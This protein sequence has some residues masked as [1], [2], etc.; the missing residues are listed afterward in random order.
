MWRFH[1]TKQKKN[2]N[3]FFARHTQVYVVTTFTFNM[4]AFA[5]DILR[6][7]TAF[8]DKFK[9]YVWNNWV[10]GLLRMDDDDT[11]RQTL[12]YE[13]MANACKQCMYESHE[14]DIFREQLLGICEKK[15][16]LCQMWV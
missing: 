14:L 12:V 11:D 10:S 15:L 2:H 5:M 8:V 3:S 6:F 4:I 13:Q 7:A 1:E 16:T 9:E